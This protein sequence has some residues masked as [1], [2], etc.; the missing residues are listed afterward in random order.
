MLKFALSQSERKLI[1]KTL[2]AG[3]MIYGATKD[4]IAQNG[5]N[6]Q[7][8]FECHLSCI[9]NCGIVSVCD[10]C[11]GSAYFCSNCG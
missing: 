6:S 11:S 9:R 1:L 5:C 2:M 7:Q 4:G 3:G 8:Y 10:G